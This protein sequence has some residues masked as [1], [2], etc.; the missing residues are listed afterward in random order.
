MTEQ[1]KTIT[2]AE[3]EEIFS[4]PAISVDQAY[5]TLMDETIRL[6]FTELIPHYNE[7][8]ARAAVKLTHRECLVFYQTLSTVC[9]MIL[10]KNKE[11]KPKEEFKDN[12][13]ELPNM[14]N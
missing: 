14:S 4:I 9:Q 13:V 10:A 2:A 11:Q 5:V 8:K 3:A 7:V 12:V 1:R 6:T